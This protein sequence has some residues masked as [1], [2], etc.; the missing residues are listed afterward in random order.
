[1]GIE[2]KWKGDGPADKEQDAKGC[3]GQEGGE[4][5][6]I[7]GDKRQSREKTETTSS[8]EALSVKPFYG[9]KPINTTQRLSQYLITP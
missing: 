8:R 7:H 4:R 9:L 2:E 5:R 3:G 1:M 6:H